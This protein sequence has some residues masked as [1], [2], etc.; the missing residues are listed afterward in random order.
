M[1]QSL[2]Q[3][4]LTHRQTSTIGSASIIIS[5]VSLIWDAAHG[6]ATKQE[7]ID[8]VLIVM[9]GLGFLAVPDATKT[10]TK[11]DISQLKNDVAAAIS[12]GDTTVLMKQ[13]VI[14]SAADLGKSGPV[15]GT[16]TLTKLLLVILVLIVTACAALEPGADPLVVRTE[17]VQA[18]AKATL[19]LVV[20]TEA[21]NLPFWRTNAPGFYHFV[22]TQLKARTIIN[23]PGGQTNVARAIAYLWQVDQAKL[24]Y[25]SAKTA[26]HSNE[27]YSITIGLS[28]LAADASGWMFA[29]TNSVH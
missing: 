16:S 22:E 20:H 17:Q 23:A 10:P 14:K 9:G 8:T 13:T 5:L 2:I 27:L 25:K 11:D 1:L 15:E 28:H 12:S 24:A 3:K 19:D 4:A 26:S 7:W 18:D 29:A 21:S 6:M